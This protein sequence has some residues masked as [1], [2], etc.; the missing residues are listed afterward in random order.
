MKGLLG[1]P[2]SPLLQGGFRVE[3]EIGSSIKSF[4]CG[5]LRV[6]PDYLED[7]IKTIFL[8]GKPV[9][10]TDSA[11]IQDGSVLALS[12]AMPGLAGAT[13]RR[14]G[15]L[16]P[17]RSTITYQRQNKPTA[18]GQGLVVIKL[19]NLLIKELGPQ[20]LGQG[21]WVE[22][23][24]FE[25]TMRT[26]GHELT[27]LCKSA[28]MDGKEVSVDRLPKMPWSNDNDLVRLTVIPE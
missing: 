1:T 23:E 15:I 22:R 28:R 13:L 7:R 20:L 21:I 19:F 2:F 27:R 11:F 3:A 16:S 26:K 5:R 14:G 9:D 24:G 25:E 8:D 4:L 17:F 6:S 10:D 18:Y 12:A